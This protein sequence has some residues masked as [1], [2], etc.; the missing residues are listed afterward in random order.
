M[1]P[2]LI[3]ARI[4]S[5]IASAMEIGDV[6]KVRTGVSPGV[7]RDIPLFIEVLG[8]I[9]NKQCELDGNQTPLSFLA[10]YSDVDDN[11]NGERICYKMISRRPATTA[12]VSVGMASRPGQRRERHYTYR[13]TIEDPD[14][15]GCTLA[16]YGRFFDNIVQFDI[17]AL[18]SKIAD[19][20]I[21]WFEGLMENWSFFFKA[22]GIERVEYLERLEDS[23]HLDTNRKVMRRTLQFLVRTESQWVKR[24]YDL[25]TVLTEIG[26]L[27][28]KENDNG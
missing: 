5:D 25:R 24:E 3:S 4:Q 19:E 11:L 26:N 18:T 23:V 20:R 28:L 2:E 12:Q 1:K 13:Q 27:K 10:E 9:I 17:Y 15:S 21:L 8:Y 16:Y 22:Y 7:S 14:H 6:E